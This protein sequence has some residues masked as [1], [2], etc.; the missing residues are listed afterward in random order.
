MRVSKNALAMV[1]AKRFW[2]HI[3]IKTRLAMRVSKR[4]G[5]GNSKTILET[6]GLSKLV[7]Q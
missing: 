7:Q 3:D 5:H 4:I 6:Y 2:K 1:I